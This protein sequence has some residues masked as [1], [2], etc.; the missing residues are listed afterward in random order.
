VEVYLAP[1]GRGRHVLYCEPAEEPVVVDPARHG[2]IWKRWVDR[3]QA[4]LA[5]VEREQDERFRLGREGKSHRAE[6]ARDVWARLRARVLAW[7]AEK[8]AEQRLLWRLRGKSQVSAWIPCG[9]EP[10]RALAIIRGNLAADFDR[11]RWWMVVDLLGGLLSAALM[12]I[13]GPNVIGYYFVFRI[14]GHFFSLRGARHGLTKVRWDLRPCGPL[15]ELAGID[16][17][18]ATERERRV[19]AVAAKLGLHR[20]PWFYRRTVTGTA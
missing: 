5:A 10:E 13:P 20:F 1:V 6:A 16:A 4:V 18:P 9:L 17:L 3:F 12:F 7:M 8:I 11:H 19:E 2:G 15:A 14:V